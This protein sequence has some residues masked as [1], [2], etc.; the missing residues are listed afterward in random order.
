MVIVTLVMGMGL[1]MVGMLFLTMV[2]R[3][4]VM[5][6]V[7]II[8]CADS[9]H[10]ALDLLEAK[11]RNSRKIVLQLLLPPVVAQCS[12]GPADDTL[13]YSTWSVCR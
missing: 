5:V 3:V 12:T 10:R 4:M 13:G 1:G 6:S 8:V 2:T 11:E 7:R 9:I